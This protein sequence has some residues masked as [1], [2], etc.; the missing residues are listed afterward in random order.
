MSEIEELK[1]LNAEL[2]EANRNYALAEAKTRTGW[3]LETIR[4]AQGAMTAEKLCS[5]ADR[6]EYAAE[7]EIDALREA[8]AGLRDLCEAAGMPCD[9]A[10]KLLFGTP[11][12]AA[13]TG[14]PNADAK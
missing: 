8:L 4:A 11:Y 12:A 2:A 1:A 10:N 7:A 9:R 5:F 3:Y 6:M 14:E 13:G